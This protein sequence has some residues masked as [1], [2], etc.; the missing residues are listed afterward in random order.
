MILVD[1]NLLTRLTSSQEPHSGVARAAIQALLHRNERLVIVPQNL[2]EFWAVATRAAGP[3]PAGK[4][5]L[6][7]T[8]SQAGHWLRF[9]QRRF[10]L[11]PD[12]EVLSQ[13]WRELVEKHVVTGYR[14]HDARLVAAM[15]T[16]GITQ[17]L[18][19]NAAD[20]RDL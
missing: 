10:T 3:L 8:P 14:S 4:N 9:F 19:F 16:Y 6:G 12:R 1:T 13:V 11:L 2:Y 15:H 18:T 7:M 20:F 5:G 17:L